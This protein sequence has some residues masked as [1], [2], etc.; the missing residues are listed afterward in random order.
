MARFLA[1]QIAVY[2]K[3]FF[4]LPANFHQWIERCDR[5]LKDHCEVIAAQVAFG[6]FRRTDKILLAE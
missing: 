4:D 3:A 5:L 6:L 1:T 2:D